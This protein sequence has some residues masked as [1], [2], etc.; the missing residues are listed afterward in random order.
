MQCVKT[1]VHRILCV[2]VTMSHS[3]DKKSTHIVA[4]V[5]CCKMYEMFLCYTVVVDCFLMGIIVLIPVRDSETDGRKD[6]PKFYNCRALH[7]NVITCTYSLSS[8]AVQALE[9]KNKKK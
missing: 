6:R 4:L 2:N 8:D 5:H 9:R 7:S 3:A 1:Q